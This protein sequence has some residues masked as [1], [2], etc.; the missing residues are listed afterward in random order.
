MTNPVDQAPEPT[1]LQSMRAA[2][3]QRPRTQFVKIRWINLQALLHGRDALWSEATPA[4]QAQ[5][6]AIR[7]SSDYAYKSPSERRAASPETDPD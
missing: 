2:A 4:T 1:W 5:I 3:T 7:A 6:V